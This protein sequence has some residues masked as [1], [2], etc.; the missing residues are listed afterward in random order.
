MAAETLEER[1]IRQ[2]DAL[3]ER[4]HLIYEENTP[5]IVNDGGFNV[6]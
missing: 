3:V 4:G 6:G 1:A 2:F 5:R